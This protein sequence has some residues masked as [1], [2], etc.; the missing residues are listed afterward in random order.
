MTTSLARFISLILNPIL[1]LV[2]VPFF[3]LLKNDRSLYHALVW[4]GYTFIFLAGMT[5]FLYYGV[6]KKLFTDM[7]VSKRTQRPLLFLASA[8]V[9]VLYIVG[10]SFS[11]GPRVLTGIGVGV[12]LGVLITSIVNTKL[13]ASIHV[14]TVSALIFALA[15]IYSGYYLFL[16]FLIPLVAWARLKIH[17]HTLPETVVGGLLGILLSLCM[18]GLA[19]IFAY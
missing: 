4:T 6:K 1:L 15:I 14:A 11:H 19:N 2:F 13:K 17:R 10:V 16:L 3:L 9:A 5:G 18:Y 12:I 7:D 8:V